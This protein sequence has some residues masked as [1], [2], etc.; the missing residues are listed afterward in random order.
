[1]ACLDEGVMEQEAAFLAALERVVRFEIDGDSLRLRA[2]D[3]ALQVDFR[4]A[5]EATDR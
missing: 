3:G 5:S 2:D 1:M 4:G